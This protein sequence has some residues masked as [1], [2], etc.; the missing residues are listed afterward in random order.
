MVAYASP[1]QNKLKMPG[2]YDPAPG[3]IPDASAAA[4][5]P[6]KTAPAPAPKANALA[7]KASPSMGSPY[8][9]PKA[10]PRNALVADTIDG[11]MRG[12]NPQ[13]YEKDVDRR[14]TE[15]VDKMKKTLALIEQQRALPMEQRAQWWEANV[16][17]VSEIM[18]QDMRAMPVD[19]NQF[20][21]QALDGHRA[22]LSAQLGI[23]PER[24]EPMSAYEA[25]QIE[26]KRLEA[27]RAAGAPIKMG[28]DMLLDPNTYT[29]LYQAT[30]K[31]ADLPEGMWYGQDGKGPPQPI[32]G[33]EGMRAR[34]AAAGRAPGSDRSALTGYQEVQTQ[35]KLDELGREL[36][37]SD[38][39][40]RA[41]LA[42]LDSSIALLDKFMGNT[43]KFNATYG[44]MMN[45]TGKK[46][47]LFN[48]SIA[49]DDNR[50]DGMAMLNQLGGQAFIDSIREMKTAGG[51]GSLSDAEG[52]KLAVAATR[53]M[54]VNQ[55]DAAAKE[56]ADEFRLRLTNFRSL[57]EKDMA[58]RK[59]AEVQR[60]QQMQAMLGRPAVAAPPP[61]QAPQQAEED[62][63][64]AFLDN[65][66]SQFDRIAGAPPPG[67]SP[68]LWAVMEDDEKAEFRQ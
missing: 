26:Q 36:E 27:E 16:D 56:A 20:S 7:A 10:Q 44:N 35:M 55:T 38:Q 51:A 18:G 28:E 8:M 5:V 4:Y 64:N 45:P 40:N 32:P 54:E 41:S 46:D 50:K 63:D 17:G 11:F 33:Y 59:A 47:D 22:M 19:P 31:P 34:I 43:D 12:F 25:A 48:W 37:A 21:D 67:V 52:S 14:K 23:A 68:E 58:A 66:F 62:E 42:T 3:P 9:Q 30:P 24:P 49:M 1:T 15:G 39:K 53:L 29:P 61:A 65:L 6:G 2:A 13:Q 57:L 60:S